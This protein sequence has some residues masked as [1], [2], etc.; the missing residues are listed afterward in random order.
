[1]R[2]KTFEGRYSYEVEDRF[3][4]WYDRETMCVYAIR[5][6]YNVES[7]KMVIFVECDVGLDQED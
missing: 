6:V 7:G 4:E 3:N 5:P 2:L 1:M